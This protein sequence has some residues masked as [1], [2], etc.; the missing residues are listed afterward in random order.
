MPKT[1]PYKDKTVVDLAKERIRFFVERFENIV[2]GVS[3]GKD[4]TIVYHLTKEVA[5]EMGELPI[6]CLWIDQEAEYQATVEQVEQWM[7][8]GGVEP[9]WF[10]MPM[11]ITN[12]TSDSEDFL[13]CWDPELGEEEWM[14]SKHELSIKE[15]N[16]GTDRFSDLFS[17]ILMEE[18][19]EST[20][21]L[22]GMRSQE[23]PRRHMAIT[24]SNT[25]KGISYGTYHG[26]ERDRW[27]TF[28]PIYDWGYKDV[29]K[30]IWDND[31]EYNEI[32]DK[33]FQYGVP[34]HKLR[35]SNVHHETSMD[36]LF[37][38]Q[39]LEPQT[40]D[41][42]VDRISGI[43]TAGEMGE[44]QY[45]PSELPHMFSDW[46][47]YRN[48]LLENL[49][50]DEEHK[51]RFKRHF[52]THDLRAEHDPKYESLCKAHVRGIMANDWE[53]QSVLKSAGAKFE[54]EPYGQILEF[55]KNYLKDI[56]VWDELKEKGIVRN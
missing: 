50:D 7:T 11:K 41:N 10:Q 6:Y 35:V 42:L 4:S 15:N 48:Y 31:L 9:M 3:G 39:E 29:W 2:V 32:Y 12:A 19:D 23:S 53:G 34:I 18:F 54:T 1:F 24:N 45:F 22:A 13:H 55:K 27:F 20:A 46:R 26:R 51:Q 47:G 36:A 16:Y 37:R 43:H 56:G 25:W 49:V 40:Y 17:N 44:E 52:L 14:R 21:M 30:Y 33:M 8:A 28:Y 38:L 5:E